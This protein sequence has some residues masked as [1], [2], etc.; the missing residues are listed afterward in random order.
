[1]AVLDGV[2]W[3]HIEKDEK[4]SVKKNFNALDFMKNTSKTLTRNSKKNLRDY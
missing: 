1:M 2:S 3:C 4:I